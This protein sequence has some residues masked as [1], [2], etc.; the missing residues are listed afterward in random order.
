MKRTSAVFAFML[1][2]NCAAVHD[3]NQIDVHEASSRSSDQARIDKAQKCASFEI[4]QF[5]EFEA[6]SLSGRTTT[7]VRSVVPLPTVQ[8]V[9]EHLDSGKTSK[10]LSSDVG[11]F[12]LEDLNP[13]KYQVWTCAEGYDGIQFQLLINPDSTVSGIDIHLAASESG[14]VSD[15]TP[16]T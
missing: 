9:A 15:V 1:I 13:G 7:G 5:G 4:V 14:G 2:T 3:R 12:R 16:R 6:A 10:T 11:R 8:V